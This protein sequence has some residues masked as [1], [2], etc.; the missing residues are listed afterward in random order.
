MAEIEELLES[1]GYKLTY[2]SG[3]NKTFQKDNITLDIVLNSKYTT[4]T[5]NK[6]LKFNTIIENTN[7]LK[8]KLKTI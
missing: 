6:E 8:S 3:Y 1:L 4:C 2:K 5:K 7:Q